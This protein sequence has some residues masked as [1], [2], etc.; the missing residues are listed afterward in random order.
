MPPSG[1]GVS[2]HRNT[3]TGT[4]GYFS[5]HNAYTLSSVGRDG[6]SDKKANA[7]SSAAKEYGI[8]V[9]REVQVTT[10]GRNE[11]EEELHS[12]QPW[13]KANSHWQQ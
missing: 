6:L 7:G 8:G 9:K 5:G 12:P 10:T 13:V 2:G 3:G 4:E 1:Y 11:S